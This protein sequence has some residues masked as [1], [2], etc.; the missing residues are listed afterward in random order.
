MWWG[1]SRR[2]HDVDEEVR[3]HLSMAQADLVDRGMAGEDARL[4]ARREF[5][6]S[7]LVAESTRD[8]WRWQ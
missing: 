2:Q 5:G 3:S 7:A 6:N 8:V 4:A 1:R